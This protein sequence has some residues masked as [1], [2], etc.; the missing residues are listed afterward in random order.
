ML[1][2]NTTFS[3][4]NKINQISSTDVICYLISMTAAKDQVTRGS[5]IKKIISYIKDSRYIKAIQATLI[6]STIVPNFLY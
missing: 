6:L 4:T 5:I 3:R 1:N 2:K